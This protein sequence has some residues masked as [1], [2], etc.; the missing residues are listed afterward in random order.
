MK[1]AAKDVARMLWASNNALAAVIVAQAPV[2][3]EMLELMPGITKSN[4]SICNLA[5]IFGRWL[6]LL[7]ILSSSQ[8]NCLEMAT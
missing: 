1:A 6:T 8:S 3:V 4:G 7:P 2:K 5:A